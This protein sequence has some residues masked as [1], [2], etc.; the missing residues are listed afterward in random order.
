MRLVS[1][2]VACAVMAVMLAACAAPPR[3]PSKRDRGLAQPVTQDQVDALARKVILDLVEL[4]K[5]NSQLPVPRTGRK[6]GNLLQDKG[7]M[8]RVLYVSDPDCEGKSTNS[9]LTTKYGGGWPNSETC[10]IVFTQSFTE[11][12]AVANG[13]LADDI[14]RQLEIGFKK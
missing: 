14:S 4:G 7:G 5:L 12:T 8:L 10:L 3:T 9:E 1:R 6:N 13:V 2:T 11:G